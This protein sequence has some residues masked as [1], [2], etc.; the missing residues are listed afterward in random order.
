[1]NNALLLLPALVQ[2]LLTILLYILLSIVKKRAAAAKEVVEERRA[3]YEDA[4]P[5]YVIKI[6]NSIRNQFEIP[7]LFYVLIFAHIVANAASGFAII[8]SWLFVISRAIHAYIHTGTNHVPSR[9]KVF[10]LGVLLILILSIN[11]LAA[12]FTNNLFN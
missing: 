6:N 2:V 12:L 3:L 7:I 1:M 8:I 11:L 9:R 4:W 5:E 10:T